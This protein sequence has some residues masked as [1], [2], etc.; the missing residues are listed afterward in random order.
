MPAPLEWLYDNMSSADCQAKHPSYLIHDAI[1][2][3]AY[4]LDLFIL[5]KHP[6]DKVSHHT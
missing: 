2:P 4:L 1:R 3:L 6:F 5:R